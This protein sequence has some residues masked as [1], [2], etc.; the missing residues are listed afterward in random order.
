M[1][2]RTDTA[3]HSPYPMDKGAL[4]YVP[5]GGVGEIGMNLSLY[6]YGGR[7]LMVDLG[8]SFG[9]DTTPGVD[10]ILPDPT[11]IREQRANLVGLVLTHAHEDHLGAIPYL[12]PELEC[13]V[14]ASPFTAAVLRAKLHERN[15]TA[16]VP[17]IEVPLSGRVDVAPF[18]VDFI[19]ITHSIP[20][21]S[22]L[23]IRTPVGTV[24]HTGDWKID[25]QPMI[26]RHADVD[27]L[28]RLGDEG[29]LALMGDST[30]ALVP[31]HS[32]SES[33]VRA[34]LTE[35]FGRYHQR[36][37]VTCFATNVARVESIA[38][39]AAAHDRA[40]GLVG[41]SLW[42]IYE[43]A[44]ANG[45]F[46]GLPPFLSEH[47]AGY[48]PRDKVVL[49]CTGSQGEPRSALSRIAHDDHPEIILEAGDVVIF[50]SRDI[51][52]NER[53]IGRIQDDLVRLGVEIL[54]GDQDLVHVSGHPAREE[55][56]E[57]YQRLRPLI[58]VPVHGE[59]RHLSEHARIA[60]SCQ[61]PQTL[62]IENG[63]MV[64]LAQEHAEVIDTVPTGRLA[65]DGKRIVP[66]GTPVMKNR[67]RM[68]HNGAA[69]VTVVLNSKGELAAAPQVAAMGLLDN[70]TDHDLILDTVDAVR[71]AVAGL[72]KNRR[73]DDAA[74]R[75]AAR[76]AVR[77][78]FNA[79]HGKKPL[80]D[81]HLVRV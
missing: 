60:E 5:L 15:L 48:L 61:V 81:V 76:V 24:V 51:P 3:T 44:K 57:L 63:Q 38:H 30:N 28:T 72:P 41:R 12:W 34:R 21:P 45:Y 23:A 70:D 54:T 4:Y 58:A 66:L 31:G 40:V 20:E 35:I 62:I 49:V 47:D 55:L 68:M 36:I 79:S 78:S 8:I 56:I 26:G 7:W 39:A 13:P 17:I 27:R 37:A 53:A 1:T 71:E 11:F 46:A 73:L 75:D 42:R 64:R 25:P 10:I 19:D 6:G 67:H 32:G 74:V 9:D 18:I 2:R 52:G 65:V 43:A 59:S 29:V 80:T 69:V 33:E 14:Y 16:R 50:S 22:I 77:R